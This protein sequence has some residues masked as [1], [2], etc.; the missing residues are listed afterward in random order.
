MDHDRLFKEL[1]TTFFVE[2]VDLFLPDVAGY[3]NPG[4]LEFLDKE[5]FTDVTSGDRHEADLVVKAA[6]ADREAFFLIHVET[7]S[8]RHAEFPR[9]MFRYFARLH[10]KFALPVYPV[11]LLSYERPRTLEPQQYTVAFP[12]KVIL[13]FRYTAIQLNRLN[14]RDYARR[15]NPLASALMARMDIA[16]ADRPKVKLECLRLLATLRLDPARTKLI[17]G[18]IDSYLRLNGEE[19]KAFLRE[20]HAV[21]PREREEVMEITTS[22]MEEGIAIGLERGREEGQ[23]EAN[24]H[25]IL[26]L[27]AR[28]VGPLSEETERRVRDLPAAR[29]EDLAEALL[30]FRKPSDLEGWLSAAP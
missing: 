20:I 17:S 10:E 14:W 1:L 25:L 19:M 21:E 28:Q 29:L 15:R 8:S 12:G 24:L 4:S 6:F 9:R 27:L 3:L 30:A 2:F 22:W 5:V 13:D 16:P 11:A 23:R 26:R 7:Q 18:F